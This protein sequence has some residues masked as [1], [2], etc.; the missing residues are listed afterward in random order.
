MSVIALEIGGIILGT[1]SFAMA[2][3]ANMKAAV[4]QDLADWLAR[5]N[6]RDGDRIAALEDKINAFTAGHIHIAEKPERTPGMP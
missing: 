2:L 1:L 3:G 5:E 4:A 6:I